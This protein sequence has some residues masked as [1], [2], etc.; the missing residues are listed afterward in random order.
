[1]RAP[2]TTDGWYRQLAEAGVAHPMIKID[3][4]D[5][6]IHSRRLP[7]GDLVRV[8]VAELT[9]ACRRVRSRLDASGRVTLFADHGFRLSADGAR[10]EHGGSATLERL[11][12]VWDLTPA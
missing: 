6:L 8:A 5:D 12:P 9:A 3:V 10:Y 1:M 11:V 2:T 4:I 7:L